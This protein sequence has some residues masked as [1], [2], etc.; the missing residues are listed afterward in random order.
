MNK[1]ISRRS[2]HLAVIWLLL[3]FFGVSCAPPTIAPTPPA[4]S[5]AIPSAPIPTPAASI[6]AEEAAWSKVVEASRKEG[7][8][9]IYTFSFTGDTAIA[10][11]QAFKKRHGLTVEFISDR[12]PSIVERL[13]TEYRSNQVIASLAEGAGPR[14]M[15]LKQ[16]GFTESLRDLPVLK[17]KN[18]WKGN[19]LLYDPDASLPVHAL[20]IFTVATNTKLVK[21]EDEPR[22]WLDLLDAR[23]KDK[24]LTSDPVQDQQTYQLYVMMTNQ[25]ALPPDYFNRLSGQGLMFVMGGPAD[26]VRALA[27]GDKPIAAPGTSSGAVPVIQAGGPIK[28]LSLKEGFPVS[29]NPLAFLNKAPQPNSARI[30]VN[31]LLSPEGQRT[32]SETALTYSFRKDVPDAAPPNARVD[33]SRVIFPTLQDLADID[34]AWNEQLMTKILKK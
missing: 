6:S 22:S 2:L 10:I 15:L 1:R 7:P 24:L 26:T 16:L 33:W 4:A 31:W 25:K 20:S 19:I 9:V 8:L 30:F 23:W 21:P 32:Y 5:P 12:S 11:A 3:V 14:I 28:L 13:K 17:D 27:R 34:K 29:A 18:V